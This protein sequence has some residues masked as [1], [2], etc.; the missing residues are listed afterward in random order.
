MNWLEGA[1]REANE[2]WQANQEREFLIRTAV[3]KIEASGILS[4]AELSAI[5]W[6]CG[7]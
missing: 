3:Q 2:E 5:K 4:D 6:E 1:V 7:V